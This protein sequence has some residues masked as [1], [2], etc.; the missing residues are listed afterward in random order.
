MGKNKLNKNTGVVKLNKAM[1]GVSEKKRPSVAGKNKVPT[2]SITNS[3]ILSKSNKRNATQS[4]K[5]KNIPTINSVNNKPKANFVDDIKDK[6]S[7]RDKNGKLLLTRRKLIFGAIGAGALIAGASGIKFASDKISSTINNID[8]LNVPKNAVVASDSF[9]EVENKIFKIQNN[10]KLPYGSLAWAN[11]SNYIA[12]LIPT[13][14]AKPIATVD[15]INMTNGKKNTLISQA[16]GQKEGFEIY[17]VRITD[18][19]IIW[20]EIN[21]L[22]EEWRIYASSFS[23]TTSITPILIDTGD[24]NWETPTIAASQN[25]AYWQV[26]PNTQKDKSKLLSSLHCVSFDNISVDNQKFT[27]DLNNDDLIESCPSTIYVSRGRMST[28]VYAYKNAAVISPRAQSSAVLHQL[29]YVDANKQILDKIC[30]PQNMKP[31]EVGYGETGFNFSFDAIYNYGEGIANLGTYT[32]LSK[33]ND[34]NNA[35]WLSF[36]RN[37][38]CA[39]AWCKG[40]FVIR[41]T[42]S[43][44]VLDLSNQSY[45]VLD[46]PNASDDYGDYLASSGDCSKIVSYANIYDQPVAGEE[47]KYCSLRIWT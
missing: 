7:Q 9:T 35:K 5:S 34:Y 27:K 24:E 30:L 23:S 10:T 17:D 47:Q 19:G 33:N 29:T 18:S 12:C 37:P 46:R 2:A 4:S 13:N 14:K 11:S 40:Y 41:S 26:L 16:V 22:Q 31:F 1:P 15:I 43:I 8:T 36:T 44:C 20:T 39:P 38:S 28:P 45:V 25:F 3:D 6:F 42:M 32:P 21:I